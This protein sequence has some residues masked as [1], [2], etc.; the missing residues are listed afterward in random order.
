MDKSQSTWKILLIKI[1]HHPN[2]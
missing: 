2:H 1:S